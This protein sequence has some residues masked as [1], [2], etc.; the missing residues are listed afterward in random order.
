MK[1]LWKRRIKGTNVFMMP[2]NK[3][4]AKTNEDEKSR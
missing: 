2:V 1:N 4:F 3:A